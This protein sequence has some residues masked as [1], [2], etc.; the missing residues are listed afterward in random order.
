MS[1]KPQTSIADR[2]F[3]R[4]LFIR[5]S[6]LG[7][8]VQSI[9]LLNAM[10]KRYPH[11]RI[12]WLVKPSPAKIVELLPSV[13]NVLVYGANH[14]EVPQYNWDGVK[15]YIR[16]LRDSSFRR[17]LASLRATRYDLVVD[18]QGQ[19]RTGIVTAV[20]GAPVR[21]GFE[22][23]RRESK[24]D[25]AAVQAEGTV[26]RAWK[27]AREGSWMA[28][29]HHVPVEMNNAHAVDGYLRFGQLLGFD[30]SH[31][32]FSFPIADDVDAEIARR[33]SEE[34]G[35]AAVRPIIISPGGLWE[36]KRWHSQGFTAVARHFINKGHHVIL[37]GSGEEAEVCAEIVAAAPGAHN[38]A[39]RTTLT[40]LAAIIRR[41]SLCLTND[42]GPMHMAV[43]LE[44][45]VVSIF[46]PSDPVWA[47]PYRRQRAILQADLACSPCRIRHVP[48]CP[49]DHACM[50]QVTPQSVIERM[51]ALLA[52]EVSGPSVTCEAGP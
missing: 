43:A 29:T 7:D 31:A 22:R 11:A 20:T 6:A 24:A 14:T 42:S 15:H 37:I 46:G 25:P 28:Y 23:A 45:P 3:E 2:E 41:A 27:G 40:Q 38:W 21:L 49:H 35:A 1:A 19:M 4:I 18:V 34:S 32:D 13:S 12:D 39:G 30:T 48:K 44:R 47:G 5:L 50:R 52:G 9:A 10:R 36:T 33:L 16:L 17:L 26:K 8:V 51:E